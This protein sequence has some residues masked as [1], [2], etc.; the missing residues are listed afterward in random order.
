[1]SLLLPALTA[2][3]E[4]SRRSV[5]GQNERQ[6]VLALLDYGDENGELLPSP[7]DNTGQSY[8]SIVLSDATFS[9]LV[10]QLYGQSNVLY[11]PNLVQATGRMGGYDPRF[12]YTIGYSYLAAV[13]QPVTPKGPDIGWSGPLTALDTKAVIADANYWNRASGSLLT[14]APHTAS[15]VALMTAPGGSSSSSGPGNQAGTLSSTAAGAMGGNVGSLDGS[16]LW[17]SIGKMSQ[18]SASLDGSAN[19]NW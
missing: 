12:G 1:M 7:L 9:N 14:V 18:Y 11:C 10:G 2:A 5:C 15:G 8:H 17:I 19:G 6:V 13:Q 4:K 16:V 3:K